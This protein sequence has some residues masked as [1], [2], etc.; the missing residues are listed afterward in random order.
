MRWSWIYVLTRRS[1]E[2]VGLRLLGNTAKDV[3][4]LVL[5]HQ[6]AVLQRLLGRPKV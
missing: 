5:R 3:E 1:L 2:L 6:H 4:L